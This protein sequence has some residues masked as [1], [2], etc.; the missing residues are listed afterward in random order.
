MNCIEKPSQKDN[1]RID[2]I[3]DNDQELK[4]NDEDFHDDV[5]PMDIYV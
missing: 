2:L 4:L 1:D 3:H 5:A